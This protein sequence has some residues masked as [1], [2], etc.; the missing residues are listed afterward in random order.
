MVATSPVFVPPDLD[1]ARWESLGPLFEALR[2][3]EVRSREELE[4]WILDRSELDAATAEARADLYIRYSCNTD[5]PAASTAYL[6]FVEEVQPRLSPKEFELDRRLVELEQRFPLPAERYGVLLRAKRNAVAIFREEN[7]PLQTEL[8]KLS[9][10]FERVAGAQTVQFDGRE[11][12]LAQMGKYFELADRAVRERAWRAVGERRL[13]DRETLNTIYASMLDLRQRVARHAGMNSYVEYAFRER[14]RFD[15]SSAECRAF[16]AGVEQHVAPLIRRLDEERRGV[17]GVE[18]LRPWDLASD[19]RGR[20][21]LRPFNGGQDL[22]VRTRGVFQRLDGRLAGMFDRLT[23]GAEGGSSGDAGLRT[24][25]LDLDSR[26]GKR[27]GGY[28]YMRDRRRL[29]FIFMNAAGLQRDVMTM[30]HEAGHA[31]H[32][33]LCAHDPLV[34]YRH[35]PTEFAEVAS[36][37]MEHLTMPCWRGSG[38]SDGFYSAS[39]A[40]LSRAQRGH[41]EDAVTILAWIATIDAFQHWIYEHP[42]HSVAEREAA[43]LDLDGRFGRGVSWA[44]LEEFQ[45]SAWQRQPH[46]FSHP[47]YYIEYGIAQLGALQLWLVSRTKG[48]EAAVNA[49]INALRLGGSR[50]L[51]ELFRAAGL[52]FD[53]GPATVGR[54]VRAV[55]EELAKLPA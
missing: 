20:P 26:K 36:M 5:D 45:R 17:M 11:Q 41:I 53:F 21:P 29:P 39:S 6:R 31:F 51:P 13:R 3:R 2:T 1:A 34:D 28:Q 48:Q 7:V 55:E 12:T 52:E 38:E 4:R 54:V 50:P 27:P 35:Y 37:S 49:Y 32:S 19:P 24:Q 40:D 47:M 10:E 30:L 25:C 22:V 14:E 23:D 42:G 46:L 16:W 8:S 43:W 9:Q 44:G 15:Y 18:T 33:L